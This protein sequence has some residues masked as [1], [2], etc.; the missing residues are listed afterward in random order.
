MKKSFNP[1][2]PF[3][4]LENYKKVQERKN[5]KKD[6]G[7]TGKKK[8]ELSYGNNT[9]RERNAALKDVNKFHSK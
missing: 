1:L 8:K 7:Q 6:K 3:R 2:D 5:K 9:L 4:Q